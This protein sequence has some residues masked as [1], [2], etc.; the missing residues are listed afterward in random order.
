MS[1]DDVQH[2]MGEQEGQKW[3]E[4]KGTAWGGSSA[5][6]H[7]EPQ[8]LKEGL[9]HARSCVLLCQLISLHQTTPKL[10]SRKKITCKH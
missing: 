8:D 5:D 4:A 2:E 6:T 3:N 10:T 1:R 7:W 9:P